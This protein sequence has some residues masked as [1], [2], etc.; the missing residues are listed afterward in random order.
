MNNM[1]WELLT[2]TNFLFYLLYKT[3]SVH[4]LGP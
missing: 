4:G 2:N 1:G 3:A